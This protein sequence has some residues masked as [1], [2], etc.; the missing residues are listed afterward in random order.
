MQ[1][2]GRYKLLIKQCVQL[3]GYDTDENAESSQTIAMVFSSDDKQKI[4]QVALSLK[5]LDS[6]V[7]MLIYDTVSNR[8]TL[9]KIQS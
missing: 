9:V 7:T 6:N 2:N 4:A 8:K 1:N 3:A 5:A